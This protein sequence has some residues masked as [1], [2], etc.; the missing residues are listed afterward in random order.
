M[1]NLHTRI[2]EARTSSLFNTQGL[3]AERLGVTRGAISQWECDDPD[4]R[5]LPTLDKLVALAEATGRSVGWF[6][7]EDPIS[8]NYEQRP[9]AVLRALLRV[10]PD[11]S[12]TWQDEPLYAAPTKR[13]G[14]A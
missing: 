11:G 10:N 1:N 12:E 5:T 3:L 14:E 8:L 9:V 2:R 7:D 4:N 6:F 13:G